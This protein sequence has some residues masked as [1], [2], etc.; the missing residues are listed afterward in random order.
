MSETTTRTARIEARVSKETLTLV[1]RA[2]EIEGRSVSDF[3]VT[4]AQAAAQRTVADLEIIRLSRKA[5]ETFAALLLDPPR[6]TAALRKAF[7][8]HRRLI[9]EVR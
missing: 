8:H 1:K 2:A 9:R 3:I 5:Q 4:A 6:P 7:K